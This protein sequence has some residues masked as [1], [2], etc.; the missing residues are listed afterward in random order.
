MFCIVLGEEIEFAEKLQ[1]HVFHL[2]LRKTQINSCPK[3]GTQC[4]ERMSFLLLKEFKLSLK[5]LAEVIQ[6]KWRENVNKRQVCE[7][8]DF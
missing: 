1:G 7:L 6:Q 5:N 2:K 3:N 4:S 8:N